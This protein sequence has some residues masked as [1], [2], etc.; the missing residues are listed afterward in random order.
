MVVKVVLMGVAVLRLRRVPALQLRLLLKYL[1]K[2]PS[3]SCAGGILQFQ[4]LVVHQQLTHM[5]PSAAFLQYDHY[6]KFLFQFFHN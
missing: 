3:P 6:L 1:Q 4:N 2:T 5:K